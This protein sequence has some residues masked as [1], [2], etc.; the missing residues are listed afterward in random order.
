MKQET[1][2]IKKKERKK[3]IISLLE[4]GMK[5]VKWNIPSTFCW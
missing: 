4:D 1:Y 3:E 5:A 2:T